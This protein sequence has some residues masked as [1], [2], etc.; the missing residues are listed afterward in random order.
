MASSCVRLGIRKKFFIE[1]VIKHW[2]KLPR[3]MIESPS[4]E[5]FKRYIDV[6]AKGVL[7]FVSH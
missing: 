7:L 3:N 5:I 4:L 1:R 6:A 2:Y